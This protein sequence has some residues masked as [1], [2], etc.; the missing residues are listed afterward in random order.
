MTKTTS[1]P[2]VAST[3]TQLKEV[4]ASIASKRSQAKIPP[5]KPSATKKSTPSDWVWTM[6]E[7][8]FRA[9]MIEIIKDGTYT[10]DSI[11]IWLDIWHKNSNGTYSNTAG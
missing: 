5:Q 11:N 10:K 9:K 7:K 1:V 6:T 3:T 4:Q 8:E 2:S